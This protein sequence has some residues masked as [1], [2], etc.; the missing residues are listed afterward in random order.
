MRMRGRMRTNRRMEKGGVVKPKLPR[1]PLPKQTGGPHR[2]RKH[3][4]P[5]KAKHKVNAQHSGE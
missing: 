2:T 3:E 1:A 5:R 4:L